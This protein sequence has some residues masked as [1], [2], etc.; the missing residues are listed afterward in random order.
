MPAFRR[1]RPEAHF[2]FKASMGHAVK[3]QASLG[4]SVRP[5]LIKLFLISKQKPTTTIPS[6]KG[7]GA[8]AP[9]LRA[10]S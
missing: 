8:M 6:H 3:F 2:K 1:L 4:N 7:D 5:C 9:W 10:K